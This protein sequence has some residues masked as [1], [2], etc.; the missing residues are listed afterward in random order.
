MALSGRLRR[1]DGRDHH[2]P[3]HV[4]DQDLRTS[5]MNQNQL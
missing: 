4:L 1:Q 3:V 5:V 2:R